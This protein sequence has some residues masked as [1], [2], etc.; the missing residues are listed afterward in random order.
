MHPDR[1]AWLWNGEQRARF[2]ALRD[3]EAAGSL[4]DEERS[5][6]ARLVHHLEAAE[7]DALNP[8]IGSMKAEVARTGRQNRALRSLLQRNERLAERLSRVLVRAEVER[9]SIRVEVDRILG[10][11]A[12]SSSTR[13]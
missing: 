6:L 5:E 9:K 12:P 4:T 3:R 2:Q 8:A 1:S 11:P 13:Q 10:D 7:A